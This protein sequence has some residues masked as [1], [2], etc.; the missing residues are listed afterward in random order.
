MITAKHLTALSQEYMRATGTKEVTL[1][2]WIFADSKKLKSLRDD[3]DI[4]VGRYN[5]ALDWFDCNW[6]PNGIWPAEV[7]RPGVS[8]KAAVA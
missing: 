1:S 8:S 6:P 3:A 7:D 4:T 5:Q 2:Y